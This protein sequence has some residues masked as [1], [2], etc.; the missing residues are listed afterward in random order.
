MGSS[1]TGPTIF[2]SRAV[3]QL[4][5]HRTTLWS[6]LRRSR[7]VSHPVGG[8]ANLP[9]PYTFDCRNGVHRYPG[10]IPGRPPLLRKPLFSGNPD[11]WLFDTGSEPVT[12]ACVCHRKELCTNTSSSAFIIHK[13]GIGILR[14]TSRDVG[15]LRRASSRSDC[16]RESRWNFGFG[17]RKE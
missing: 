16:R 4:A 7:F 6:Q 3:A 12:F 10:S 2:K 11:S 9:K 17:K 5:E 1:P 13:C 8:F 15:R 14:I